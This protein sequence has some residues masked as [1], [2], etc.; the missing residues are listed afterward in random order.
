[1]LTE[2]CSLGFTLQEEARN[3]ERHHS[4]WDSDQRLRHT[5]VNF[6]SAGPLDPTKAEDP[7]A[8]LAD[9]TLDSP[10]QEDETIEVYEEEAEDLQAEEEP[11]GPPSPKEEQAFVVD[12]QG[13]E[14]VTTGLA[15][16]QLRTVSPTPSNSSEEVILFAGRDQ[17]GRAL[18]R[19]PQPSRKPADPIDAKIRIVEDKI[20]YQEELLEKVLQ[21]TDGAASSSKS[22]KDSTESLS[23]DFTAV[24]PKPASRKRR[25]R[26]SQR[27]GQNEEEE[28]LIADYI[29]NIDAEEGLYSF[30]NRRE[31]G[32]TDDDVW[33]D[34]TEASSGEAVRGTKK[35]FHS[36]W[37]PSDICDFDD[38]STSDGV[39]GDVQAIL[40][41][42]ERVAGIQYLVV[43]EGQTVDEARW[44]PVTT[45]TSVNAL[46]LIEAFEAEEKLVAEFI[47]DEEDTSDTDDMEID[48]DEDE[49]EDDEAGLVQRKI[50]RMSDEKI[51][52]LLAKQEELG[53]GSAELMLFDDEADDGD[54]DVALPK[55]SFSPIMLTSKKKLSKGRGAKRPRGE[56]PAATALADAYDGFDV[57]DFD[58]PSLK[59]KPKGRKGK[60]AFDLSD[61]DLE[62][63]MQ[64]AWENDRAKK[65]ER[66]Q[67][68]E[69]LRAQGLLGRKNG[70]PDLKQ[71][72]KEGMGIHAV[73]E[74][75]K[76]FL[77]GDNTT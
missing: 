62:A 41:K 72:Y 18:S 56:F 69:E 70:K 7:E 29:A 10:G 59:K 68:R 20:H 40:S 55:N 39:M 53:M 33:Q 27:N 43:W 51:A 65:K 1:M 66:K 36:S 38:L 58:R 49:D 74:E 48:K 57:M 44:V 5:K 61:S 25:G 37:E 19:A 50:E 76:N 6:V 47:N 71:K 42:R 32:G 64:M 35:P 3:T 2:S 23:A 46:T 11:S 67:D 60:M 24:S 16:P 75:I 26:R 14:P 63:S 73:K 45:L 28:A 30:H 34:E 31:L 17:Q 52:R 13:S 21:Q 9:M 54:E 12:T 22:A 77:M 15:P 8:A 4:F